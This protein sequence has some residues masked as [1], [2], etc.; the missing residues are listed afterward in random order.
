VLSSTAA[1]HALLASVS[2]GDCAA[3]AASPLAGC[4]PVYGGVTSLTGDYRVGQPDARGRWARNRERRRPFASCYQ[5]T[6][7]S[8]PPEPTAHR[9]PT[10]ERPDRS[11][12]LRPPPPSGSAVEVDA[13]EALHVRDAGVG[14]PAA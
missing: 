6:A 7:G 5:Y 14:R 13:D 11:A 1:T 12:R 2:L 4:R 10:G 9:D 3:F 8:R